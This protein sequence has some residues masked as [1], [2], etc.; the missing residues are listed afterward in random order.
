MEGST[1]LAR[2]IISAPFRFSSNEGG[3]GDS[4]CI[5][6]FSP[7]FTDFTQLDIQ[8]TDK[9][10]YQIATA[11]VLPLCLAADIYV[12][13]SGSDS[14]A[15]TIDAPLLSI[16]SAVNKVTSGSTIYLRKG[17]Y[18]PTTNIQITKSGSPSGSYILRAYDGEK[19]IIDGE[20]LPGYVFS[21]FCLLPVR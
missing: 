21:S 19:V 20:K 1:C 16:Q 8:A 4:L 17:T 2:H 12:S 15:G 9:M 13:P 11:I 7:S 3:L 14:A 10:R 18:S 5:E 6:D